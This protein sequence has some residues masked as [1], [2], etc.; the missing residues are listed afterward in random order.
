MEEKIYKQ[1]RKQVDY[2][3]QSKYKPEYCQMLIDW[4]KEGRS[5][6]SFA[7]KIEVGLRTVYRWKNK[8]PEFSEAWDIS[9]AI[10]LERMEKL[11]ERQARGNDE[12]GSVWGSPHMTQFLMKARYRGMYGDKIEQDIKQKTSFS[13][14]YEVVENRK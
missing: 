4:A 10:H 13:I 12:D 8:Y 5:T 14:N 2:E 3:S 7:G 11:A 1:Q 9:H 6:Q